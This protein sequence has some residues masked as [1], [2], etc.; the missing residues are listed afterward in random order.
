M[1][2]YGKFRGFCFVEF[3]G[4]F[5]KDFYLT[6]VAFFL[7]I[8]EWQIFAKKKSLKLVKVNKVILWNKN[9]ISQ[10]LATTCTWLKFQISNGGQCSK[11][12]PNILNIAH[13]DD[14]SHKCLEVFKY[15]LPI[16]VTPL[17]GF[18]FRIIY[19]HKYIVF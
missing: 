12:L 19:L 10:T 9:I 3:S 16:W 2:K 8:I 4:F 14:G 6:F 11:R 17:N 5:P 1:T 15:L 18:H 7:K 13:M